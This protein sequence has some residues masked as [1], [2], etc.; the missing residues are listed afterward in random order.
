MLHLEVG[1]DAG[2]AVTH[3]GRCEQVRASQPAIQR[4]EVAP[5]AHED[6]LLTT[7]RIDLTSDLGVDEAVVPARVVECLLGLLPEG[8][9]LPRNDAALKNPKYQVAT[10]RDD[11]TPGPDC[12]GWQ[13]LREYQAHIICADEGRQMHHAAAAQFRPWQA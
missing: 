12:H 2:S 4:L 1:E 6:D 11:S 13:R 8:G 10:P 9:Y 5:G 7:V 3:H